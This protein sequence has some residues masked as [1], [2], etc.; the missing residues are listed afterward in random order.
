[1]NIFVLDADPGLCA[2]WHCDTHVVSQLKEAGQI[3]STAAA[4][5][6]LRI[7]QQYETTHP[8][9]PCCLWAA[10]SPGNFEWLFQLAWQLNIQFV[11]RRRLRGKDPIDHASFDVAWSLRQ[12]MRQAD[13][14]FVRPSTMTPWVQVM[15]DEF[16]LPVG[17]EPVSKYV[18]D[19]HPSIMAY[20]NMYRA[21]KAQ[22]K[23]SAGELVPA[24]WQCGPPPWFNQAT[25]Q[26]DDLDLFDDLF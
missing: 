3:M 16:R 21:T 19:A 17:N 9:H 7:D 23:N 20:R 4:L 8:G 26:L 10:E 15:P 1:M 11:E 12:A 25:P 13:R 6:G 2:R 18:G 24:V 5:H 14:A 22:L